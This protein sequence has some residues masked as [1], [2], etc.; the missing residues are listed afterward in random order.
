MLNDPQLGWGPQFAHRWRRLQCHWLNNWISHWCKAG[1]CN[2]ATLPG[3]MHITRL[4]HGPQL[5]VSSS[6][7]KTTRWP[8]TEDWQ[9]PLKIWTFPRATKFQLPGHFWPAGYGLHTPGAKC[10]VFIGQLWCK[11]HRMFQARPTNTI[12][13]NLLYRLPW[14]PAILYLCSERMQHRSTTAVYMTGRK[15]TN[16]P[17]A[18]LNVKT[19]P[20]CSLY[21]CFQYSFGFQK[22]VVFRV[23]RKFFWTV[24]Q[25]FR[26]LVCKSPSSRK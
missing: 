19:G 26:V 12:L 1:V 10:W 18:K 20:T 25:W 23:F 9:F 3:Q 6:G 8:P 13:H 2:H 7:R 15:G 16:L 17:L 5:H 21:F 14:K 11:I 22:I 4:V 24:F